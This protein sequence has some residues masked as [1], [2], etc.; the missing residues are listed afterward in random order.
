MHYYAH[1]RNNDGKWH[2]L[3]VHLRDV[4][5]LAATFATPFGA[6]EA[7]S[8]LGWWH[9]AGKAGDDWQAFIRAADKGNASHGPDHSSIGMLA[10][11]HASQNYGEH[12]LLA[13]SIAYHHG[14]LKDPPSFLDRVNRKKADPDITNALAQARP[15]IAPHDDLSKKTLFP[16]L[17]I[18]KKDA[19]QKRACAMGWRMLHSCLVDADCL[20]TERHFDAG[21]W[22]ARRT[23]ESPTTLWPLFREQLEDLIARAPK[24]PLNARRAQ[25]YEDALASSCMKPGFF[26]L[27]MPTGAGKTLTGM[28][29]SLNHA[30]AY[31]KRRVICAIPYTSIIEQNASVY[32]HFLGNEHVLEHHSGVAARESHGPEDIERWR[33]L[34]SQNWDAPVIVTTNVQFFESLFASKNCTLRKLHNIAN[35]VIVL[36]EVQTLPPKLLSMTLS[37]LTILVEHFGC[38]VIFCTAT[39]PA[40]ELDTLEDVVLEKFH[41][42]LLTEVREII[43]D[44]KDHFVALSR[45]DYA[46]ISEELGW[47]DLAAKLFAEESP[48]ALVIL[49]TIKD[50]HALLD[51]LQEESPESFEDVCLHLSTRMCPFHRLRVLDEVK[52]RLQDGIPCI[53]VSTQVVE[54]GVDIDFPEVWRAMGPLDSIVQAAGR[55]N[56]EGLLSVGHVNIFEPEDGHIPPGV[57][58]TAR[59][60]AR[61]MLKR[62]PDDLS[63]LHDPATFNAYFK[64]LYGYQGED[65]DKEAL[66]EHEAKMDYETVSK[67]YRLIEDDTVSVVTSPPGLTRQQEQARALHLKE[68]KAGLA[69]RANISA[70]QRYSVSL[71]RDLVAEYETQ[72]L[73]VPV[74][75]DLE[76]YEWCG[77]YDERYG[78]RDRHASSTFVF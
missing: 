61:G 58:R 78:L 20:D 32:K 37:G 13:M 8:R 60:I 22:N 47:S 11:A 46:L 65:L 64:R 43:E 42:Q 54:A 1:T 49:N 44:P 36:D 7:A 55:C 5:E 59:D 23:T 14:G 67:L 53:L 17:L 6:S 28:A 76:L 29:F 40:F 57:Y 77:D 38:S 24:T 73:L 68:I 15:I 34:A 75:A 19:L 10:L 70:L 33:R 66:L 50:A 71:R 63:E 21:R 25:M 18:D 9:D 48:S 26:S 12:P 51:A 3:L 35:S 69:L 30:S 74:S 4:A 2:D 52:Q 62:M 16:A 45:V 31:E 27:S 72:G 41:P 56:R 39:Q